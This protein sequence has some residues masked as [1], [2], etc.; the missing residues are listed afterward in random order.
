MQYMIDRT[1]ERT[2]VCER[3]YVYVQVQ[4][5]TAA[6]VEDEAAPVV[7]ILYCK[8]LNDAQALS[9]LPCFQADHTSLTSIY[10]MT[11]INLLPKIAN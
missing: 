11:G 3:T 10:W 1:D 8:W 6:P 7:L 5:S 9:Q 4:V 2:A